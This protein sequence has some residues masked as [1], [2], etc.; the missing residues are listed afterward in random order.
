[1]FVKF[2]QKYPTTAS[3]NFKF[4]NFVTKWNF[5]NS[6]S[7]FFWF[8]WRPTYAD[9]AQKKVRIYGV[10]SIFFWWYLVF[11]CQLNLQL[12]IVQKKVQI[13]QKKSRYHLNFWTSGPNFGIKRGYH[14]HVLFGNHPA[15]PIFPLTDNESTITFYYP[16][17]FSHHYY[18]WVLNPT[19][20]ITKKKNIYLYISRFF[21]PNINFGIILTGVLEENFY[22][23]SNIAAAPYEVLK[24]IDPCKIDLSVWQHLKCQ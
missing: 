6:F 3:F 13:S 22:I 2:T 14:I 1:M 17:G 9:F 12:V 10:I 4:F 18:C 5:W 24:N 16:S 23:I 15:Y 19:C 7:A 11:F 21:R 8:S 20:E